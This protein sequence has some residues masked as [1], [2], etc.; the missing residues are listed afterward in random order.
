MKRE[1]ELKT[2]FGK[3]LRRQI[4]GAV[5]VLHVST[6][7]PDRAITFG[8]LTTYLEFKHGTPTFDSPGIQEL[9]CMRLEAA[10][11]CRYVVWQEN[12]NGAGQ[13]TLIVRPRMVFR[14]EGWCLDAEKTFVGFDHKA[15]V[16]WL[17][18]SHGF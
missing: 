3:E 18:E 12:A 10:G 4:P 17:W 2:A 15:A 7:A 11:R 5:T 8:G 13:R 14:R 16:R 1:A 9:C 6:G